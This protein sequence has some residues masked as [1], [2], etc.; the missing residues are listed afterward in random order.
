MKSE[1][2]LARVR[3]ERAVRLATGNEGVR[4]LY[5]YYKDQLNAPQDVSLH[6]LGELRRDAG[7]GAAA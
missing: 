2:E 5:Q 4:N 6:R 3:R 1:I 7:G